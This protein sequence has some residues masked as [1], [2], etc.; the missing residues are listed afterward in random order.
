MSLPE[1][2]G[3]KELERRVKELE[4]ENRFLGKSVASSR[5]STGN[6]QVRVHRGRRRQPFRGR[7]VPVGGGFPSGFYDW[8]NRKPSATAQWRDILEAQIRFCF[9][10]SD[11]TYGYRRV[12][13]RLARWGTWVD[14]EFVRKIMSQLGLVPCQPGRS[15]RSPPSPATPPTCP[16]GWLATSPPTRP[17]ANSSAIG[18]ISEPGKDGCISPQ[19]STAVRRR[20]LAICDGGSHAHRI[21]HRGTANGRPNLPLAAG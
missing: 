17:E 6:G 13:A 1:R 4:E 2:T 5:R 16:T 14:P 9:D 3:L 20:S 21:D 18:T 19:C 15:G 8:R 11:G 12:H 7:H 10:H